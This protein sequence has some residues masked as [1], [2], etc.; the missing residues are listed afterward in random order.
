MLKTCANGLLFENG[1]REWWHIIPISST[2]SPEH[3]NEKGED[4]FLAIK[5][6]KIQELA[7]LEPPRTFPLLYLP[8]PLIPNLNSTKAT[9]IIHLIN[10]DLAL[11]KQHG[12][13]HSSSIQTHSKL[14]IEYIALLSQL[15]STSSASTLTTKRC[16][17]SCSGV[18]L[19]YDQ[20]RSVI[21]SD[22]SKALAKNRKQLETVLNQDLVNQRTTIACL[23]ILKCIQ[24]LLSRK[25]SQN[26]LEND[27]V[28]LFYDSLKLMDDKLHAYPPADKI[29]TLLI[30]EIGKEF[31]FW[32]SDICFR[33]ILHS[34][35]S[36]GD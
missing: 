3:F 22:I 6:H 19:Q 27:V 18:I 31:I 20:K 2:K 29:I 30:K 25:K 15:Y 24:F 8:D 34:W 23:R 10:S 14:D 28:E 11:L 16:S 12:L 5:R 9:E 32:N 17:S 13:L 1:S 35:E 33:F 21:N 26:R 36:T 7:N 4:I